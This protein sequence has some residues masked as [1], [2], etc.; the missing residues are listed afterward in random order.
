MSKGGAGG[1][2]LGSLILIIVVIFF[3]V[4]VVWPKITGLTDGPIAAA[5]VSDLDRTF[6]DMRSDYQAQGR[7]RLLSNM[8]SVRQFSDD[9]LNSTVELNKPIPFGVGVKS[10]NSMVFCAD[11]TVHDG[12]VSGYYLTLTPTNRK[13][14]R[15]KKFHALQTFKKLQNMNYPIGK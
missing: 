12:G 9:M 13:N 5:A 7:L 6:K 2:G 4:K 3:G 1:S 15:C 14:E 11:I 8:T 10:K